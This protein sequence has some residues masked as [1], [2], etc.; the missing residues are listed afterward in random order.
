MRLHLA[1]P[2]VA[3]LVVGLPIAAV[4]LVV[5]A[6]LPSLQELG[7][8]VGPAAAIGIV[9]S[10]AVMAELAAHRHVRPRVAVVAWIGVA[11]ATATIIVAG[12]AIAQAEA[13]T[14]A[15]TFGVLFGL[16][17]LLLTM[18]VPW[19]VGGIVW[20]LLVRRISPWDVD[21]P[22][23]AGPAQ[24]GGSTPA[25]ASTAEATTPGS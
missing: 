11:H 19:V 13:S 2:W 25:E 10:S 12:L 9:V 3:G 14:L 22:A 18:A 8:G 1:R 16:A 24:R 6:L 23:S 4:A 7:P 17:L 5:I 21:V 20:L 15:A